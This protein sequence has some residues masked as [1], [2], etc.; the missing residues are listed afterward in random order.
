MSVFAVVMSVGLEFGSE[1]D[2]SAVVVEGAMGAGV[3]TQYVVSAV[4]GFGS[5]FAANEAL[6]VL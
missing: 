1:S 5:D 6:I 2:L 3:L 4:V